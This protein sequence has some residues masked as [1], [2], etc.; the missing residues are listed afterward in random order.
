MRIFDSIWKQTAIG[1]DI[2]EDSVKL[3]KLIKIFN[4]IRIA[5]FGQE[6]W[7]SSDKSHDT[8]IL[9]IQ[10]LFAK[11]RII[12]KD[13][14]IHLGEKKVRHVFL[15]S[16]VLSGSDLDCWIRDK[17]AKE[18][19]I[20]ID[21]SQIVFSYHMM[22]AGEDH[23]HLL[24]AY[25]QDTI[26][27]E[28]IALLS[29]AGLTPVMIGAGS[30]DMF[31]PFAL[32]E[33]DIFSRTI[34][35][36]E[37]GKNYTNSLILE[38]GSPVFYRSMDGELRQKKRADSIF[39]S[40]PQDMSD[41]SSRNDV[42]EEVISLWKQ[43]GRSEID[44]T[45]LVGSDIPESKSDEMKYSSG[46]FEVGYPLQNMIQNKTLSPE[47]SL[48]AGLALKKFFPLLD[49]ID[50]LP[51]ER[52][53]TIKKQN[54]KR[55]I[56]SVTVGIGL[57]FSL[58]LMALHIVKMRIAMKLESTEKEM[59]LHNDQIV[60]IE[61]IKKERSQLEQA[62]RDMQ[63]LV[64]RRSHYAELLEEISRILPNKLWLNQFTSIPV[65]ESENVQS[66]TRQNK[67]LLHG[68]AFQEEEIALLLSRL[69]N[70]SYFS[71]V[72]LLSTER[73]SAEAVWKRSKLSEVSLIQFTIAAS[74]KYD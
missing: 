11:L 4:R 23:C 24:V 64:H 52:K 50:L 20:P 55:R 10:R 71:D 7:D 15:K 41:C 2:G 43:T 14:I 61:Q 8:T 70:F 17:I 54:K 38:K 18:F 35:F 63:Q 28:R 34:H 30:V 45:I 1:L 46:T 69:E 37:F 33:S 19:P 32:E 65:K 53:F 56:L 27:K 12:Q 60:A 40:P 68:W 39:Q 59:V 74:L 16:P 62:L 47:Y 48:A 58:I 72:Q 66:G 67:A 22:H 29:E 26:L 51:E 3:V 6:K 5:S 9:A 21:T 57:I 49:T 25:C 42:L 73:I 13:V 36:I 44:R 31:L